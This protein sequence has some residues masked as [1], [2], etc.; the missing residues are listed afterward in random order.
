[1][2]DPYSVPKLPTGPQSGF[3]LQIRNTPG[4]WGHTYI[5]VTDTATGNTWDY[6][7][8]PNPGDTGVIDTTFGAVA[9]PGDVA[10][11]DNINGNTIPSAGWGDG[12]VIPLTTG[13]YNN[14]SAYINANIDDPPEYNILI[15]NDCGSFALSVIDQTFGINTGLGMGEPSLPGQHTIETWPT[16]NWLG[17]ALRKATHSFKTALHELFPSSFDPLVLDLGSGIQTTTLQG[18]VFFDNQNNGFA[19]NTAWVGANTGILVNDPTDAPITNGSQMFG[20]STSLSGGGYAADGFAALADLDSNHDGVINSSDSAWSGLRVWVDANGDGVTESGELETMSAAGIASISLTTTNTSTTDANGNYIGKTAS[21]SLVGGGTREVADASFQT[22]PSFT[23]ADSTVSLSGTISALPDLVGSG[24]VYDLSQAM[25]LQAN[26]SDTALEGYVE[27]F[28]AATDDATRNTLVD[29]IIYQWTGVQ[30]VSPTA[31]GANFDARQLEALEEFSGQSFTDPYNSTANPGSQSVAALTAAYQQLHDYVLAGLEAQTDLASLFSDMQLSIDVVTGN[32]QWDFSLAETQVLTDLSANR[33]IGLTELSDFNNALHALGL[34]TDEGFATFR[35]D[36]AAQGTD[37]A[38]AFLGGT[39]VVYGTAG[40]DVI[41]A[42]AGNQT[43][44][45]SQGG[46]DTLIGSGDNETFYGSGGSNLFIGGVGNNEVFEGGSNGGT[47]TFIAG[48]GTEF[49][50]DGWRNNGAIVYYAA[51]DGHL[52]IRD[53]VLK[54]T[55]VLDSSIARSGVSLAA[56]GATITDGTTGDLVTI[57]TGFSALIFADGTTVN[58]V[59]TGGTHLSTSGAT[60][61]GSSLDDIYSFNPGTGH[62]TLNDTG[63]A[64]ELWLGGTL[65]ASNISYTVSGNDLLITDGVSGDQITD[66]SRGVQKLR[67]A[68][69]STADL[70]GAGSTYTLSGGTTSTGTGLNDTYAFASGTGTATIS[71][72]GGLNTLALGSGITAAS[73]TFTDSGTDLLITD[74]VSG[75]QITMLGQDGSRH[76]VGTILFWG[77]NT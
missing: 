42:W 59:T 77:G 27:S 36:L 43:V 26:A 53:D 39:P 3:T 72:P 20:T 66:L 10:G 61:S 45:A 35:S 56:G 11:W 57:Q 9:G 28:V 34:D 19:E 4:F 31:R 52:T 65:T 60:L 67:F 5:Q 25:Q 44:I 6:G 16:F 22:D 7:L 71:D 64:N 21:Y 18:G 1:M 55:L 74:G 76:V 37:V 62:V 30:G 47:D 33:T 23:A 46:N 15:G 54:G 40:D 70:F 17:H 41:T 63:G 32:T 2:S 12:P 58:L 8:Y 68:D 51:G 13:Q 38:A 75:E 49:F 50:G 14:L 73:L 29:E 48:Q 69:G 24:T